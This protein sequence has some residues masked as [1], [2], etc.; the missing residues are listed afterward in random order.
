MSEQIEENVIHQMLVDMKI[1]AIKSKRIPF[2]KSCDYYVELSIVIWWLANEN[3][4]RN[5]EIVN[6]L[7]KW[8]QLQSNSRQVNLNKL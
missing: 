8:I 1:E 3:L 6:L 5:F 2:S 7:L 4:I